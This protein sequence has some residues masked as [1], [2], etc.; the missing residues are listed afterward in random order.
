[1]QSPGRHD[2]TH[3]SSARH[4]TRLARTGGLGSSGVSQSCWI[5]KSRTRNL[6]AGKAS[7][8]VTEQLT[9]MKRPPDPKFELGHQPSVDWIK[10]CEASHFIRDISRQ[11]SNT[12]LLILSM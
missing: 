10:A 3:P 7:P 11:A 1:M 2:P 12:R 6:A 8:R 5:M 9:C 4:H